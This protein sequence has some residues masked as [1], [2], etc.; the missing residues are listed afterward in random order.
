MDSRRDRRVDD[1]YEGRVDVEYKG[2]CGGGLA[3]AIPPVT[4][5][6]S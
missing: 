2:A 4:M 3:C 1:A 5:G 6:V